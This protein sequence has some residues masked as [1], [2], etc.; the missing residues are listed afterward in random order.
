M[1]LVDSEQTQDLP[2][3]IKGVRDSWLLHDTPKP[4]GKLLS[5]RLLGFRIARNMVNQAQV[6]WH[7]DEETIVC[8]GVQLRMDQLRE[9]IRHEVKVAREV[10]EQDLCF[11]I[12]T[13]PQ[14]DLSQLV[15]NWD[16][17]SPRQSFL[18]DS[19]HAS[20]IVLNLVDL[21]ISWLFL[22]QHAC[23]PC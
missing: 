13:V 10:L 16:A 23:A 2:A 21:I 20:Q 14:Y 12:G 7:A 5:T 4:V 1:Q 18:T 22:A 11:E 3:C 9:L 17:S 6:R 8:Q 15:D 19:R